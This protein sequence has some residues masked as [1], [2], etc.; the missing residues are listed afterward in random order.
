MKREYEQRI[1]A[2]WE[3]SRRDFLRASGV[4]LGSALLVPSLGGEADAAESDVRLRFGIVTDTHYADAD[5]R[6]TRYYRESLPKLGE[7]VDRI[8]R[9]KVSFLCEL[10][11][12]KD[13]E[14]PPV[15]ESTLRFL[16]KIESVFREFNGPGYHIAGNHDFD[17]ISKKQF[18][19]ATTGTTTYYSFDKGGIHFVVLDACFTSEGND[20]DH[21]NFV[22][23]D[24]N[25]SPA[26]LDWLEKNLS[27]ASYPAVGFIHQRLD[28][29]GDHFVVNA[30]E[31]RSVLEG[32]G[33]VLAVFQGHDHRG[34]YRQIEGIHYYTLKAT[35][36][37]SGEEN[38][39]YAIVE[40]RANGDMAVTGYR[41]AVSKELAASRV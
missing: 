18:L 14:E 20:Y 22:W 15:E 13:Q 28:G 25:I 24:A 16:R 36:E 40:V 1:G 35:I 19:S 2:N 34:D 3:V 31:V 39:S 21:S 8:N 27:K 17:S 12:F 33:K 38:N 29:K 11:D 23:T 26:E 10:G 32:S 7:C 41:R 4:L 5:A 37:G 6:G 30:D 9:E